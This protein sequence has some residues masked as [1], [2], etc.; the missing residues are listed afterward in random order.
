MIVT[1][2]NVDGDEAEVLV[3]LCCD[4][5]ELSVTVLVVMLPDTSDAGGTLVNDS[6]T[7]LVVIPALVDGVR[8]IELVRGAVG[9]M[10]PPGV[11]GTFMYTVTVPGTRDAPEGMMVS[12]TV[13]LQSQ[14]RVRVTVAIFAI[15]AP[16][17]QLFVVIVIPEMP[18][19]APPD[20][21]VPM[22][23]AVPLRVD[24]S[25]VGSTTVEISVPDPANMLAPADGIVGDAESRF[26]DETTVAD[27]AT[28]AELVCKDTP[29]GGLEPVAVAPDTVG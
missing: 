26:A 11:V 4:K 7:V 9:G 13:L 15:E 19:G 27:P 2:S 16:L 28:G 25:L 14:S 12:Y 22:L 29:I 8:L 21:M 24:D 18:A 20:E 6:V 23:V 3:R 10:F 17:S 5:V 1:G